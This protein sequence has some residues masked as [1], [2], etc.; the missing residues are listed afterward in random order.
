MRIKERQVGLFTEKKKKK[1]ID[2]Q[3]RK[4]WSRC[5]DG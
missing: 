2:K 5:H 4:R 3:M 1:K